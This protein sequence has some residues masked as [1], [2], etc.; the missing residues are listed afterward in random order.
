V[1]PTVCCYCHQSF[2]P[3]ELRPY[4]PQGASCCGSCGA[5]TPER[6]A[7]AHQAMDAL[8][9]A[10]AAMSPVNTF[11]VTDHGIEPFDPAMLDEAAGED[12]D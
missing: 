5:A 12:H 9:D 7:L 3:D 2:H 4:G 10:S 1:R 6:L 11:A 8:M